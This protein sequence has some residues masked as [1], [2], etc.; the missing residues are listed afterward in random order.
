[1]IFVTVGLHFQ[2]FERL[3]KKIDEIAAGTSE[4][5]IVQ[6]GH[7][8][9]E[10]RNAEYFKS[11]PQDDIEELC[12]SARVIIC[13][14]GAG[15]MIIALRYGKPIIVVPRLKKYGEILY[16]N[17]VDL[18]KQLAKEGALTLVWDTEDLPSALSHIDTNP[19]QFKSDRK[20]VHRLKEYINQL[21]QL[22][23]KEK[24]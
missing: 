2:G 18:G 22:G 21:R 9:Y 8:N 15:S 23:E 17:K 24:L 3:V 13:H 6:I 1:M 5:V 10:P 20:L 7:T 16:D 19:R 11:L 4:K 12:R 14:D